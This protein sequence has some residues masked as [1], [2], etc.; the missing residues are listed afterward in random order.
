MVVRWE[1]G[2]PVRCL[3]LRDE[4][5]G[6]SFDDPGEHWAGHPGVV[7]GRDQAAG[8]SWCVTDVGSG[9][10]G[11]VL[12]RPERREAE[13]GT[14]S[15]GV[16]PLLLVEHGARWPGVLEVAG[17]ASF[18]LLLVSDSVLRRWDFDG[19]VLTSLEMD[20]GTHMITSGGSEDRRVV[21]HAAAFERSEFPA[22]WLSCLQATAPSPDLEALVVRREIDARVYAT[23]FG[24]LITS[25]P[26]ELSLAWT[27][28]PWGDHPWVSR[29]WRA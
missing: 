25:V 28:E 22:G 14:P 23:V 21:R 13:P 18:T 3:A 7:G 29:Q 11:L 10:T 26:G 6:R 9:V 20:S 12:N 1:P 8:G 19:S 17:M 24:Q 15:R 5:V 4:L 2:Q 16:L 27:R